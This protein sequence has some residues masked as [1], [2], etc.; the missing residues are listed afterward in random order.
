ML[1]GLQSQT[2]T[3]SEPALV[4][5]GQSHKLTCSTS[6]LDFK[7]YWMAWIRQAPGKGLEFVA[8][9]EY[10][11]DN[12]FYSNAVQGRFT[13]SRDNNKEQLYL[14]MNSLKT[15]DTAVYYCARETHDYA[16][17]YWGKGT[18]VTVSS[19]ASSAPTS[20]FALEQCGSDSSGFVTLG[21]VMSGFLPAN[22]KKF[23][24]KDP[25]GKYLTDF[26]QYPDIPKDGKF[27]KISQIR[28]R[29]TDWEVKKSFTCEVDGAADKKA[30]V[31]KPALPLTTLTVEPQSPVFTGDTVTLTCVI[32]SLSGW[33]YKWYKGSSSVPA[34]EGNTF[35][36]RGAAESHKGQYWC[37]GERRGRPTTSQPSGNTTLDVKAP[38]SPTVSVLPVFTFES[39]NALCVIENFSPKSLTVTWKEDNAIIKSETPQFIQEDSSGYYTAQSFLKLN[40]T[41]QG[42]K[43]VFTCEV[44]HNGKKITKEKRLEGQLSVELTP[45]SS[46]DIFLNDTAVLKCIITGRDTGAVNDAE[47]TWKVPGKD[48]NSRAKVEKDQLG[49]G[50]SRKISK[51]EVDLSDWFSGQ[52]FE[53]LVSDKHNGEVQG[54]S[55]KIKLKKGGADPE[56]LI[57]T[58]PE[59]RDPNH[60]SVVC[61]VRGSGDVYI[62]W[63]V[64]GGSYLEGKTG[65]VE[66]QDG[67][68]SHVSILTVNSQSPVL[69]KLT[70]AVKYG[71]ME[72]YTSPKLVEYS[73]S[74]PGVGDEDVWLCTKSEDEEED[75]YS[76]MWSTTTSFIFLFLFSL[77]YS[78]ILSLGKVKH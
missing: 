48:Q 4:K 30:V 15:E 65:V 78:A 40:K 54:S 45:P 12:I 8:I 37:Q 42:N 43:Q 2:L 49:N 64:D 6:G 9:I 52:E 7:S 17:D 25:S 76:S 46:R 51:L 62:M 67:N 3:E 16:F 32:E 24:W 57:Y 66:Q 27:S 14:Q 22:S 59:A 13:I 21:C 75:E 70:C 53:C 36:I 74:E 63:Q 60:E 50:Q 39:Q 71:G 55:Q 10:D 72:S 5:P 1:T 29:D 35:T 47:V 28:V 20:I 61:E 19:G 18:M 69:R 23:K 38:R 56:V 73:I 11:S 34:P 41:T 31:T 44:S 33:T 58:L 26:I 68:E 77:V